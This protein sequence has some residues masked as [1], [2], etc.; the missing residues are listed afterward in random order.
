[1]SAQMSQGQF[2]ALIGRLYDCAIEP[3]L[4]QGMLEELCE[5]VGGINSSLF[6]IDL[7]K[8]KAR[9]GIL[10]GFDADERARLEGSHSSDQNILMLRT[11]LDPACDPDEPLVY[12][13]V[14]DEAARER[15]AI[16]RDWTERLGM[17]DSIAVL[18]L[19]DESYLGVWSAGR[20]KS[21]GYFTDKEV[22]IMRAIAP[23]LRRA[24][25]IS[26][27]L[28]TKRL[29]A[30]ALEV[31]LDALK[32]A[33]A[34][35]GNGGMLL[36]ANAAAERHM[37]SGGPI[38]RK[39]GMLSARLPEQCAA[40]DAALAKALEGDEAIGKSGLGV[41]LA[42]E[43]G[44]VGA[45]HILPLAV[46]DVRTRLMPQA[47]AAVFVT[48]AS[49]PPAGHEGFGAIYRLTQSET[50]VLALLVEGASV[51]EIATALG[52]AE[53][54]VR[55]HLGR[56]YSKTGTKQQSELVALAAR[57]APPLSGRG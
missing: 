23:H 37:R 35:V 14:F 4:W 24:V 57:L 20:H 11:L 33:V 53:A 10:Q 29:E 1:M 6:V 18:A 34:I 7:E 47:L 15:S 49:D 56:L 2:S 55:T 13:R 51:A 28:D 19:R 45:A 54:T 48:G 21:A 27:V 30:R 12:H 31:T 8:Q 38:M 25:T 46:G 16:Y 41:P 26:N 17:I 32:S 52:N 50:R 42:G 5:L 36:H 9:F 44:G 39:A 3:A 40:F 43:D 22:A